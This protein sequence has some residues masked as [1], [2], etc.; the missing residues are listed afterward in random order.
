MT[1]NYKLTT[2]TRRIGNTNPQ[3]TMSWAR[4][5]QLVLDLLAVINEK[6]ISVN[7]LII[8]LV[9]VKAIPLNRAR[10]I[11]YKLITSSDL[12]AYIS[13]RRTPRGTPKLIFNR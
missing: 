12:P 9:N 13:I 6:E 4:Q 10:Q 11:V 3:Q 5:K 1:Y 7:R 8:Y 2:H